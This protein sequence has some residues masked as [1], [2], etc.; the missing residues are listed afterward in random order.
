MYSSLKEALLDLEKAGMLKRIREEV[1]PHLEM[2]EIA[3]QAFDNHGPA[4]LFENIKG[5]KFQAAANIFG[6]KERIDFLFRD[7]IDATKIAVNFKSNPIDFF[8]HAS[9]LKLLQAARIGLCALPK[10]SGSIKD[11][12][13]CTLA[14]IPQIVGW[15]ED[16][17]A[18]ITLPQVA[19]RPSEESSVLQT[20][21]GMYRIQISGNDYAEDECGL[22]YQ[23]KRD[24]ARHHEKALK[25]GRPL[26]VSVFIGGPPAHTI[27]AVMPMPEN[28]SELT[29][30]GML[31]KKRFRYFEHDGY[32]VSS[33]ADFCILGEIASE[34]K[35]EGP[36]G[37]HVGYYSGK[38]PYPF[39]KVKK[40]LHKKEAIYPFTS[41]GRPPKEDTIFGEFI[42]EITRPMVPS[43]IPGVKAIHAVDA[44]GVHPL[45][46]SIG[47]EKF[48]PYTS[49]DNR[50]P[51][52]LLKTA[53]ALLGFNQ[54]SLSKYLLLTAEEDNPC[55]DVK[56]IPAFFKHLLE[57]V[58]FD[59]DLHFQ[60]ATTIDTLDYTG[61][62]LNHGSKL[63]IVACG[64]QIRTLRND[65]RDFESLE[66][67]EEFKKPKIAMPGVLVFPWQ[68]TNTENL[69]ISS[70]AIEAFKDALSHWD[71]RENYPWI[72]IANAM[73][74]SQNSTS[75]S[76][77]ELNDFL[78]LT[79]TRSDPAQDVYGFN[80]RTEQKHWSAD[81][82]IIVDATIKPH[83]QNKLTI[84]ETLIQKAKKFLS[85][86]GAC[87]ILC[88]L[89]SFFASGNAFA[90]KCGT[91]QA[92][93]QHAQKKQYT[94]R[95]FTDAD[96]D[97]SVFYD[98]VYTLKTN[99]FEIFYTL[100]GPHATTKPF[101][102]SAAIDLEKAWDFH[103]NKLGMKKPLGQDFTY[104]YQKKVD[105]GLYPVEIVDI[106]TLRDIQNVISSRWCQSCYGLTYA[107]DIDNTEKTELF[108]ENDFLYSPEFPSVYDSVKVFDHYCT[109]PKATEEIRNLTHDFSY[110]TQWAK[111]IRVT[112]FHELY[113]A[114][115]LRYLNMYKNM[116]FWFEASATGIEE[117]AAPDI[118]DYIAY[119]SNFFKSSESPI[120][121]DFANYGAGV[122]FIYLYNHYNKKFDKDIWEYFEKNNYSDFKDNLTKA[123]QKGNVS[124]D[125]LF[126]DFATALAFAGERS[127]MLD[128]SH[129]ITS[130]QKSWP[131]MPIRAT[132][133]PISLDQFSY[134]FDSSPDINPEN[135]VGKISVVLY[136]DQK[137]EIKKMANTASI[138]SI[139]SKAL[140]YDSLTWI[141]SRFAEEESIPE[142]VKD[143]TL[144]VYPM[145]WR[146]GSLC[147][148]PL[149]K[150]KDFI[151]I[152][153]RRGNLVMRESYTRTTHCIDESTVKSQMAPGL[154]RFRAGKNGKTKDFL[155]IY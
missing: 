134:K 133:A 61:K 99:H 123:L 86:S 93:E 30:A 22:H 142:Y 126:H 80:E 144:R 11:F 105:A 3:R 111:G 82:P 28:L 143:S 62:S 138:D 55:L 137:A 53:N 132:E 104:H 119:L 48:I 17:G 31:G 84:S 70:K 127:S 96:C 72:T 71:F 14:D 16:G 15:P 94:A 87:F 113:H 20:N 43:S 35:P 69:Q 60:T 12:E 151:E 25:E 147:F 89:L 109:Y 56:D 58:H 120:D 49:A 155:V 36:F 26:K 110:K 81:A 52:E 141:F 100:E 145:P 7:S 64:R 148:T 146:E 78:W 54:V 129:W 29:F 107:E 152:R 128:S 19:S 76:S 39:L 6:T 10:K 44:A 154:Y 5:S 37:D 24:I 121:N 136:Q 1:D 92:F 125:S 38:H 108:L 83:Y 91:I 79:F 47:S 13:E 73:D 51:L 57:R 150:N 66:L 140:M 102:D 41:V 139:R 122:L 50:E 106:N 42:H 112:A 40:V 9:P 101:V 27:A 116:T 114:V 90:H 88:S 117:V 153:N 34:L 8:K 77:I 98:S 74:I 95:S 75:D 65:A 21:L 67:P 45:C 103:V 59:R 32:L 33:D 23:I 46:L 68:P 97:A 18:F 124:A 85:A 2:A 131:N 149:P 115:Q 135:F 63:A 4:L 130:D 118:D